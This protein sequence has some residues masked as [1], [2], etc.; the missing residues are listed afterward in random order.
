MRKGGR[1]GEDNKGG[2]KEKIIRKLRRNAS[3]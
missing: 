3:I 2:G 1:E